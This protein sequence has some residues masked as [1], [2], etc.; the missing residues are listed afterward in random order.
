M[1]QLACA[2]ALLLAASV[3]SA[4]TGPSFEGLPDLPGG[5]ATES[6]AQGVSPD[7]GTVVGSSE[8]PSAQSPV[9][10]RDG[11]IT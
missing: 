11:Q 5:L 7:G 9:R 3:G 6:F 10:W 2:F 8:G 4:Q 1:R